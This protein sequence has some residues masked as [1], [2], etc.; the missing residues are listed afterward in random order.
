MSRPL[1]RVAARAQEIQLRSR[2]AA[3]SD[4]TEDPSAQKCER[5]R[6]RWESVRHG[7]IAD[8]ER[9]CAAAQWQRARPKMP[10]PSPVTELSA[11]P[12]RGEGGRRMPRSQPAGPRRLQRRAGTRDKRA[13]VP[14]TR[15]S[16]TAIH[17]RTR[18]TRR[19]RTD[20]RGLGCSGAWCTHR[21]PRGTG[22]NLRNSPGASSGHCRRSRNPGPCCS[23]N[24]GASRD[25][26]GICPRGRAEASRAP[27]PK[28]HPFALPQ[29]RPQLTRTERVRSILRPSGI[30][31][32]RNRRLLQLELN[33]IRRMR[34]PLGHPHPV[35]NHAVATRWE[36]PRFKRRRS[37]CCRRRIAP[38]ESSNRAL[39]GARGWWPRV[40]RGTLQLG[41]SAGGT[42]RARMWLRRY[43]RSATDEYSTSQK[44]SV[45]VEAFRAPGISTL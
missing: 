26:D 8:E 41:L 24:L 21:E 35:R 12:H 4:Q 1:T 19:P 14:R 32:T 16:S 9:G 39:C 42:Q 20:R 17:E 23:S 3:R 27:L 37:N 30:L 25:P 36:V 6:R 7:H 2:A 40:K 5:H 33:I 34:E 13:T 10:G 31:S 38:A 45:V 44:A 11:S 28:P 18:K 22:A 43:A 15:I 29:V